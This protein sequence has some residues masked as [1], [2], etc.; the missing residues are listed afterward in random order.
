MKTYVEHTIEN[1]LVEEFATPTVIYIK[2]YIYE[3]ND[4]DLLGRIIC[5]LDETLKDLK[6]Y[7]IIHGEPGDFFRITIF[8][9]LIQ[10]MKNWEEKLESDMNKICATTAN[11]KI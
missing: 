4:V 8:E 3:I 1:A 5:R 11:I 7:V 9:E 6:N 10:E 2:K